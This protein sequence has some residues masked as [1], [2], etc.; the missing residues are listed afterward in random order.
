MISL[1]I[2]NVPLEEPYSSHNPHFRLISV[3]IHYFG[4][5]VFTAV[6]SVT[7]WGSA[8]FYGVPHPKGGVPRIFVFSVVDDSQNFVKRPASAVG[9]PA[10]LKFT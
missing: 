5:L 10:S 8:K 9:I 6:F 3:F 4:I 2:Y 7:M 1:C